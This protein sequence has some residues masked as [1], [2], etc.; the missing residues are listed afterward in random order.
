MEIGKEIRKLIEPV[1]KE[2]GYQLIEVKYEKEDNNNFLRVIINK[3]GIINLND[4]VIVN[5]LINPL[6]DEFDLIQESYILDVCSKEKGRQEDE[7]Q[8]I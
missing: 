8:G 4:C 3:E 1:I 2:K 5:D 7:Y 6:L